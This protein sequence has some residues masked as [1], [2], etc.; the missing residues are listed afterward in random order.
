MTKTGIVA[1]AAALAAVAVT[2]VG[3]RRLDERAVALRQA[4]V[5]M[6]REMVRR[7][8]AQLAE[9][10][11]RAAEPGADSAALA[12]VTRAE[13]ILHEARNQEILAE[14]R[15]QRHEMSGESRFIALAYFVVAVL[16]GLYAIS[17]GARLR[18][19]RAL[20]ESRGAEL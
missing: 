1:A 19:A 3:V 9:R 16:L 14:D 17:L 18:S 12:A 11:A 10:Q 2:G 6:T 7:V 20:A 15:L 8:E 13:S 4:D 5:A